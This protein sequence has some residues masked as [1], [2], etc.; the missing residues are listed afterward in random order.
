MSFRNWLSGGVAT[1]T[2]ATSATQ[3][4]VAKGTVATVANVAVAMVTDPEFE[5]TRE[6]LEERAAFLEFEAGFSRAEAEQKSG[7]TEWQNSVPN[8]SA[9]GTT[10]P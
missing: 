8:Q 2:V 10:T 7:L 6:A 3:K 4:P 1:A 5:A 9:Q